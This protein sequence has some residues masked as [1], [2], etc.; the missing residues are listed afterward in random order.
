[1]NFF[2][3]P[4]DKLFLFKLMRKL[5]I[6]SYY[7]LLHKAWYRYDATHFEAAPLLNRTENDFKTIILYPIARSSGSTL[8]LSSVI[9]CSRWPRTPA[10]SVS[11]LRRIFDCLVSIK[12]SEKEREK[13]TANL[14]YL[15]Y[16]ISKFCSARSEI[17]FHKQRSFLIAMIRHVLTKSLRNM[18]QS[19]GLWWYESV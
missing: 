5:I 15:R 2:G 13:K 14:Y 19:F 17:D 11:L 9:K 12:W 3:P 7:P 8:T 16:P 18:R 4:F 6:L 1:M 10:R